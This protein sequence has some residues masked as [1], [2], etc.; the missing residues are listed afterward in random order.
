MPGINKKSFG[1]KTG[2][3]DSIYAD[4][5]YPQ[6]E[7]KYPLVVLLHGFMAWKDWGF[8]PYAAEKIAQ[9]GALVIN[10]STSH[11]G[12]PPGADAIVD[13]DKFADNTISREVK[14]T[15]AVINEFASG[16]ILPRELWSEEICLAGHSRGGAEALIVASLDERISKAASW[17]GID[18][19]VRYPQRQLDQFVKAGYFEFDYS[20]TG[21]KLRINK[22][23]L[24][25]Y[26]ANKDIYD[27]KKCVQSLEIPLLFIHGEQDMTVPY[28]ESEGLSKLASNGTFRLIKNTG[29][30]FGIAHPFNSSTKAFEEVLN[31][32]IEFFRV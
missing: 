19:F 2:T 12:V 32:T 17:S 13:A 23:Y 16:N 4:I 5:R 31:N 28:K 24:D 22:S 25:D 26:L 27:P 15:E 3:G 10:F 1:V 29:H 20:R 8:F 6:E 7:G 30:T 11:C 21:K 18:R 9:A 14:D